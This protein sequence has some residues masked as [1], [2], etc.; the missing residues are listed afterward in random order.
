[1]AVIGGGP[2]GAF[3]AIQLLQ[4][5][6]KLKRSVKVLVFE[7]RYQPAG[8]APDAAMRPDC[9]KGCNHCAGGIS[10]ALND[11]LRELGLSLPED[12][13]QSRIRSVTIQGHWKNI[14]LEVPEGREM[15]SV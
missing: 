5:A 6:A 7:R 12:M 10:P 14:T 3:F 1:M 2:A 9:W 4:R 13:V 15:V 11:S 8:P